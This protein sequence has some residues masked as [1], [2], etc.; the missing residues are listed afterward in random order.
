M[1]D[2]L[3]FNEL[4]FILDEFLYNKMLDD[5]IKMGGY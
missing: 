2:K 1:M 5:D 3:K 4:I